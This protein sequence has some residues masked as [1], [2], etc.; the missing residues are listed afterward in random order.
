MKSW[1][2]D[3]DMEMHSARNE[4]KSVVAERFNIALKVNLQIYDFSIKTGVHWQI[5]WYN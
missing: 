2:L 5:R 1:L 3:N 4:G